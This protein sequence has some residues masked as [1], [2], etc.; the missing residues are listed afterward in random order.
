MGG[1]RCDGGGAWFARVGALALA[2]LV[3]FGW[4][5]Q[6]GAYAVLA[7]EAIIDSAWDTGIR[8]LL[9][10]RFPQAT[11]E[12]LKEAHGYAYGGAIIQDMGY[13]P[14]GSKFF[15]DLTH[16]VRS[17]DFVL[18]LLRDARD[19][20]GYA[21]ALGALSHYAADNEGHLI[22]VNPAVPILY[23]RLKKKYGD[24]VTYE[25]NPLAH[26]KTEFGFDVLEVAQGRYAPDSYHDFI[27]FG[28]SVPLLEQAFQETYGLDLKSVLSDENKVLGSYRYDVSQLLPKATRI[29]WS[30]KKNDIM[31]DQPGMTKRKFLYNLSRA[32]Y[33]KNWGKEY[34]TPTFGERLLAFLVRI[35]PKIGPLQVL[36]LKTPTPETERMFEASFN[37]TM[38]RYRKLLGQAG[39]AQ[40]DL[41]NDNFDTGDATGPGKYRLNDEAHAELLDAL[42]KQNFTGASPELRADLLEFYGHPDAPYATKRK[43]KEWMKVQAE[44][45]RLKM[46]AAPVVVGDADDPS[47]HDA[48]ENLG[49]RQLSE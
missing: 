17:G 44:L 27:G 42:A 47:R 11:K 39:A 25:E 14:H 18:A 2:L 38:D 7:H 41:P 34:Q 4:P 29:A 5:A 19:L 6:T 20:D 26:V 3:S 49:L 45:E 10:E 30:L 23:P 1:M 31:K 22:G 28:V 24:S 43:P 48:G 46:A 9:L 40:P 35:L 37:A 16:Y 15:S 36:E 32:S 8:P 13:Y 12:E 21:F 33:Q